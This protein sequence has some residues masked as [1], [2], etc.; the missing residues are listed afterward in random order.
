[1]DLKNSTLTPAEYRFNFNEKERQTFNLM[2]YYEFLRRRI[3]SDSSYMICSRQKDPRESRFFKNFQ[4]LLNQK[5]IIPDP[6]IYITAQFEMMK[7]EMRGGEKII[8]PPSYLF[9]QYAWS[10]YKNYIDH[11]Y[12]ENNKAKETKI[13][14]EEIIKELKNT[15]SF[16]KKYNLHMFGENVFNFGRFISDPGNWVFINH[17]KISYYFLSISRTFDS[18]NLSRIP[19]QF[20]CELP[21]NLDIYKSAIV[22]NEQLLETARNL[23][24]DELDEQR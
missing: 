21:Q 19:E 2:K 6:K 5:D 9:S 14:P 23:F 7:M 10:R 20:T 17:R 22:E 15:H 13:T 16:V 8:C 11:M 12:I 3:C 1:M 18:I 24:G 4:D